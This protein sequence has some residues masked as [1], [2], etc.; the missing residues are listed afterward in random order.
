MQMSERSASR[1]ATVRAARR[2][3]R[4]ALLLL[5][6]A[7]APAA[8]QYREPGETM[9]LLPDRQEQLEKALDDAPWNLGKIRLSPWIGLRNVNYVRELDAE[10]REQEGDLT[11][12]A[13]AGLRAYLKLG[14]HAVAA[15]HAIPEYVWWQKRDERNARVGRYGLGLFGWSNRIE[16]EL[17]A[18]RIEEVRFLSADALVHEPTRYDVLDASAQV[19]VLASIAVYGGITS[20]RTRIDATSGLTSIDPALLLDR[21]STTVRGGLRYLLRG[22]RGFVGAGVLSERTEFQAADAARSNEGSSWYAEAQLKGN[23]IDVGVQYDQHQLE[24]DDSTFPGYDTAGGSAVVSLHPGWRLKYQL[25]GSRQ[26]RYSALVVD[27][28]IEEERAGAAVDVT[29]GEGALQLFYETGSD[30]Y[31]GA[32]PRHDD[33]TSRGA[34]LT[35]PIR[36]LSLRV[37]GRETEFETAGGG[38]REVREVLGTVALS[39]G[40]PGDW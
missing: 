34:W 25:Y 5:L 14:T 1:P 8:A 6:A 17:T 36:R 28:F 21:D 37:G 22:R 24:A 18:R 11:A 27:S 15:A 20:D 30:D 29:L 10:G 31:F 7:A 23:H 33:V 4:L 2:R 40:S 19:R 9:Q 16:G 38:T 39:F 26:L 12:T 32:S 3:S 35:F 13:G